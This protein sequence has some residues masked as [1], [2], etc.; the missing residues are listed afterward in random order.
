M[1]KQIVDRLPKSKG[2]WRELSS[3]RGVRLFSFV[4][5]LFVL[6]HLLIPK[7][8]LL[9]GIDYSHAVFDSQES[10]LRLYLTQDDRYRLRIPLSEISPILIRATLLHEDQYFYYHPGI[11]PVAIGRAVYR[12]YVKKDRR[13]GAS[14]ITMQL[15]RLRYRLNTRSI[16]GKLV[17]MLRALQFEWHYSKE[18]IL[19]A[20]LNLAPYGGNVEGVGSASLVYFNKIA[21]RLTLPEALTL[22]VIPQNPN[23]RRPYKNN[24]RLTDARNRLFNRWVGAYPDAVSEKAMLALPLPAQNKRQLPFYA[25]HFT[26]GMRTAYP[27]KHILVST[28]DRKLQRLLERKTHDYLE[29]SKTRGINNAVAMLLDY[30]TMSVKAVLGSADFFNRDIHGEVDGSRAKRSPGST[31]KPFLY[32]IGID[33]GLIHPMTMLK[34]APMRFGAYNPENFDQDYVGPIKAWKALVRSRNVP[35]VTIATKLKRPNLYDLLKKAGV[36]KMQDETFYGLA[37]VLG[38]LETSMEELVRLYAMLA[39]EGLMRPLRRLKDEPLAEGLRLL[40]REASYLTLDMLAMNPRPGQAYRDEWV[41]GR[42]PVSW[43]TGTSYGF[44]D[45]WSVGVFGPYVLAVWTGNFDGRGHPAFV[46]RKAAAPLFFS[47]VDAVRAEPNWAGSHYVSVPEG[48]SQVEVCS[49]SGGLPT[50]FCRHTVKTWFIP[51]K[52]PIKTCQIHRQVFVDTRTGVLACNQTGKYVRAEVHEYWPSDLLKLFREAGIPRR[53]PPKMAEDCPD[54]Q[55][56][57]AGNP[58]K[59]DSP[60]TEL[61]YQLR[62][63]AQKKD[64]TIPLSAVTD[65]DVRTIYWF[66]NE[67][68][69]GRAKPDETFH[70]NAYSGK[71]VIRVVDDHGRAAARDIT[72]SYVQ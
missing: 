35:A 53:Q 52:S 3:R 57:V 13:L 18:E 62:S 2:D 44:R 41:A 61:T 27:G 33:Q 5:I 60:V 59:I 69:I 71:H 8:R 28:L 56:Q 30:R 37:I 39:N 26:Q 55:W 6:L 24:H 12:T 54:K 45:A 48:I 63:T 4:L 46:G 20:Y 67:R 49:V 36:T 58:P 15:A 70:W 72:V 23:E 31:L 11:N 29:K 32:A 50:P 19:E 14:T 68:F 42:L 22:S 64:R 51:G 1:L 7:P 40:S 17:Q 43:K 38:G 9:E 25:P 66:V 21:K 47:I 34:D 65:A 16:N 10:L